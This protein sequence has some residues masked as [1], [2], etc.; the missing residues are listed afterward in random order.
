MN[1]YKNSCFFFGILIVSNMVYAQNASKTYFHPAASLNID[2][3]FTPLSKGFISNT[4][5]IWLNT[6][7]SQ[8]VDTTKN[9]MSS[10]TVPAYV[11]IKKSSLLNPYSPAN[12]IL[13]A[14]LPYGYYFPSLNMDKLHTILQTN[15]T[16]QFLMGTHPII[17]KQQ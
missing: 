6:L 16:S 5:H 13:S 1:V 4:N 2:T 8:Y 15:L 14:M 3:I 12:Q 7:N 10:A 9:Q 17:S 11:P